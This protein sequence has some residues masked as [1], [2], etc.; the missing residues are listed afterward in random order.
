L[1]F[2]DADVFVHVKMFSKFT[3]CVTCYGQIFAL[4]VGQ[5]D[6]HSF[7]PPDSAALSTDMSE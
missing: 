5:L 1:A 4:S 3:L 2:A 6:N 7:M